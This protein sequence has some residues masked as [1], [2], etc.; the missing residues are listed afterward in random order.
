[1]REAVL[2]EPDETT[3]VDRLVDQRRRRRPLREQ[4]SERLAFVESEGCDIH[5]ADDAGGVRAEGSHHL[6]AVGMADDDRRA[7]LP[8]ED[9]PQACDVVSQR[10][11]RELRRGDLVPR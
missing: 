4:R 3:V 8:R 1:M 2:G 9:L 7:G 10:G 11:Q 6:A 5:Q